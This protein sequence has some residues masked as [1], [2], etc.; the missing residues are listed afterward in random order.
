[1]RVNHLRDMILT[2]TE[3]SKQT[4]GSHGWTHTCMGRNYT[5]QQDASCCL[6]QQ[7]ERQCIC[8]CSVGKYC[9]SFHA[10]NFPEAV[11]L[12]IK[13]KK[14]ILKTKGRDV[15]VEMQMKCI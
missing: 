3:T 1:M 10:G 13:T 2:S 7:R 14:N 8:E 6:Q 9:G 11:V 15:T 4:I 5:T 12:N